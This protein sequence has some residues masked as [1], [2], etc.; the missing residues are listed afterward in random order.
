[1]SNS[2]GKS[3]IELAIAI[4]LLSL[5]GATGCHRSAE[6]QGPAVDAGDEKQSALKVAEAETLYAGR[7]DLAK[8]RSA[9]AAL[10]AAQT[11]DYGNY[12]AAW[13]LS[14]A[15][16]FV[17]DHTDNRDESD[18]MF[19]QGV[20]AGQAAVK[21]QPNKPEGHLWLGANYGGS[22]SNS[23]LAGLA[24][25][26]DIKNEMQAVIK[27]DPGYESGSAYM[28]LG[29]LYLEA[30][31]VLGGDPAKAVENL[32]KGLKFGSDNSLLRAFLAQAYEATNRNADAKKQ[33][34]IVEAMNPDPNFLPEHKDA[35]V[36]I[37]KLKDKMGETK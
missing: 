35:L 13:K 18:D 33:M 25:V 32:E 28:G 22:A 5:L 1:M 26:Q 14:R 3:R 10:R 15:A 24:N 9:V 23:T 30:P 37:K 34:E 31:H 19:R 2:L 8:A 36:L 21:L 4:A 11:A 12:E 17:G 29:R 16:Y 20:Q 27:I 6:N 7:A